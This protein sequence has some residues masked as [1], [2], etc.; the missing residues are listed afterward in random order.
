MNWKVKVHLRMTDS[1]DRVY[2]V[3]V[4][5]GVNNCEGETKAAFLAGQRVRVLLGALRYEVVS[6]DVEEGQPA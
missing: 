6:T 5:V 2:E 3:D 1:G 4:W